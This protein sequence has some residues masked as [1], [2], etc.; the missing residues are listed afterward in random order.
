MFGP[1]EPGLPDRILAD[2][3]AKLLSGQGAPPDYPFP[4]KRRGIL[5]VLGNWALLLVVAALIAFV[6]ENTIVYVATANA[7][8]LIALTQIALAIRRRRRDRE[9]AD[10]PTD[11]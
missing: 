1:S 4:S 9:R 8:G 11:S 6:F 7:L 10:G 3:N 2:F 5:R